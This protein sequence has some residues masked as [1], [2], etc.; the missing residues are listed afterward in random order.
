MPDGV[1]DGD[2]G[3]VDVY[4]GCIAVVASGEELRVGIQLP[5]DDLLRL[6]VERERGG[7]V[8]VGCIGIEFQ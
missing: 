8:V 3:S 1:V 5:F 4:V 7:Q 6:V 2:F